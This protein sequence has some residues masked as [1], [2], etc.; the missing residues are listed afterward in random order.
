MDLF[1]GPNRLNPDWESAPRRMTPSPS[2]F[3]YDP[4]PED[5]MYVEVTEL[6]ADYTPS[7]GISSPS[8]QSRRLGSYFDDRDPLRCPT[9]HMRLGDEKLLRGHF[10]YYKHGDQEESSRLRPQPTAW[11]S[12]PSPDQSSSRQGKSG[13]GRKAAYKY[14]ATAAVFGTTGFGSG[15]W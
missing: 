13:G 12:Q 10:A 15:R 9:C 1:S 3:D 6:G 11:S 2:L 7:S 5:L 8:P 4:K 14:A